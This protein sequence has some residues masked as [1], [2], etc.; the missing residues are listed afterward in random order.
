MH[1]GSGLTTPRSERQKLG[2]EESD[3][4][5]R[6]R[7]AGVGSEEEREKGRSDDKA[8]CARPP[9]RHSRGENEDDP[10]ELTKAC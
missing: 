4:P 6:C 2:Y 1:R 3:H 8:R 9:E 10:A 7:V 5:D